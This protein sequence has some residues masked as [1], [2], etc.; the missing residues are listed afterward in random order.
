M[1]TRTA[2]FFGQYDAL[3]DPTDGERLLT[4]IP[5]RFLAHSEVIPGYAH[6][7]FLYANTVV[8][9]TY[10]KVLRLLNGSYDAN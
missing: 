5:S 6:A 8:A 2:V 9:T 3:G 7:D 10:S 1:A 4:A